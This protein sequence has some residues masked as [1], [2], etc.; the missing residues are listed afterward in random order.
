MA[1]EFLTPS[2]ELR[3]LMNPEWSRNGNVRGRGER[4]AR[5]GAHSERCSGCS[6]A[7]TNLCTHAGVSVATQLS[8]PSH[9][10]VSDWVLWLGKLWSFF[11][12]KPQHRQE[13]Q[14]Y[15]PCF[16]I[17][18]VYDY[19]E[20]LLCYYFAQQSGV[21]LWSHSGTQVSGTPQSLLDHY[22]V[23]MFHT[24]LKGWILQ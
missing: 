5:A 24:P 21:T 17:H 19:E 16:Y 9:F 3:I 15:N 7:S 22:G 12:G 14:K 4:A 8:L 23:S 18:A 13:K 20:S 2:G 10:S 6:W 11:T 1:K